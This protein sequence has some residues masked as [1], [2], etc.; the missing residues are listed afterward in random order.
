M[1]M[2][3]KLCFADH[4]SGAHSQVTQ[5]LFTSETSALKAAKEAAIQRI[6]DF[7]SGFFTQF[8]NTQSGKIL[9]LFDGTPFSN[10]AFYLKEI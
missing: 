1:I 4:H 7:G 6:E 3:Y 10:G 8:D 2:N 9:V 5:Q